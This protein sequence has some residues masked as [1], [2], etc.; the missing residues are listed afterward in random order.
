MF[1]LPAPAFQRRSRSFARKRRSTATCAA[2]RLWLSVVPNDDRRRADSHR[3]G[4]DAFPR[5]AARWERGQ[6]GTDRAIEASC[7]RCVNLRPRG[8]WE[9]C[10]AN[11]HDEKT[12]A[13]DHVSRTARKSP[14]G[15][16]QMFERLIHAD[17][18]ADDKKKWMTAAERTPQGWQVAA[19][20]HV[21]PASEFRDCWLFSGQR[22]GRRGAPILQA[23]AR[24]GA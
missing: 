9:E 15:T 2:F 16:L 3:G 7:L 17:W 12:K 6:G 11:R 14:S 18:S 20:R 19:P 10:A 1:V 5:L 13:D 24:G 21:P 23:G 8:T 4:E 22:R